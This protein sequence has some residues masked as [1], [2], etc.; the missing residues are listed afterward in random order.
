MPCIPLSQCPLTPWKNGGGITQEL[1]KWGEDPFDFRISVAQVSQDGPF[2]LYTEH[3]RALVLLRGSLQLF[4]AEESRVLEAFSPYFFSG[5]EVI[6]SKLLKGEVRD[7]NVIYRKGIQIELAILTMENTQRI[8]DDHTYI[9]V[10]SGQVKYN[11]TT[12]TETLF[13]EKGVLDILDQ[14]TLLV[15]KI[16]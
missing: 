9:Y 15:I 4:K 8:L 6:T 11:N 2:S 5:D 3:D 13:Y 16:L 14:A 12:Y 1:I 7:F 10:V